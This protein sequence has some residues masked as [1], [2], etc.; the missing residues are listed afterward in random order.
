MTIRMMTRKTERI[1]V[2]EVMT[3]PV[4][5]T[6]SRTTRKNI[7]CGSILLMM[8]VFRMQILDM[9]HILQMVHREKA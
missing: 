2:T 4:A 6:M 9:L 3:W 1:T 8:T 5:E 7:I